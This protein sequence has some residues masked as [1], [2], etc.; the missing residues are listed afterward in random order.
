[1]A[2][3]GHPLRIDDAR[4]KARLADAPPVSGATNC[5]KAV[6]CSAMSPA[7][8]SSSKAGRL[9]MSTGGMKVALATSA[10][11][12]SLKVERHQA[13]Q[14]ARVRRSIPGTVDRRARR[15]G[16]VPSSIAEINVT[17]QGNR[18]KVLRGD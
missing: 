12:P 3:D 9:A 8:R 14:R 7:K 17:T 6:S 2:G 4:Q 1:M 13:R 15:A 5:S 10:K 11:G 16:V 18:V